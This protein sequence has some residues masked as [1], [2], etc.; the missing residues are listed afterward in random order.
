MIH[1]TR[2]QDFDD[3]SNLVFIIDWP[4]F[5][6]L[7]RYEVAVL[8]AIIIGKR[9][10]RA[11]FGHHVS[12]TARCTQLT[13]AFLVFEAARLSQREWSGERLSF[14]SKAT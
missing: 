7:M 4:A 8:T 6:R 3:G 9:Q 5:V 14:D 10:L 1:S 13:R 11:A 12:E 2:S